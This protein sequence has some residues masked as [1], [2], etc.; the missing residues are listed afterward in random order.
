LVEARMLRLKGAAALHTRLV[1]RFT[2]GDGARARHGIA[3]RVVLGIF[4]GVGIAL[5]FVC[6]TSLH[7]RALYGDQPFAGTLSGQW[8]PYVPAEGHRWTGPT[9]V[10]I[11]RQ[12]LETT[13]LEIKAYVPGT[14][15]EVTRL[16]VLLDDKVVREAKRRDDGNGWLIDESIPV[17]KTYD[18]KV[19]RIVL[20]FNGSHAP[21]PSDLDRR[22]LSALV[23]L[24][25]F[26]SG[27]ATPPPAQLRAGLL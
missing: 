19:R 15:R 2:T 11:L 22:V 26:E 3:S 9:A 20:F 13:R 16:T 27:P 25:A 23:T 21:A 8:L 17:E 12:E 10:I 5:I 18:L 4:V 7:P 6:P 14:F 24:V 1:D